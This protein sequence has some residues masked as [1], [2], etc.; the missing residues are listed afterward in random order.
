MK[1]LRMLRASVFLFVALSLLVSSF[2][3]VGYGRTGN[4]LQLWSAIG[5]EIGVLLVV[6]G[7]VFGH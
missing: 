6:L 4:R 3:F 5:I 1:G 7:C 2:A